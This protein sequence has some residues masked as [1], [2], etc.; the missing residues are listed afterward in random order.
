[1]LSVFEEVQNYIYANEGLSKDVAFREIVKVVACKLYDEQAN[2]E[3][4]FFIDQSELSQVRTEGE[5]SP[6]SQ[7]MARLYGDVSARYPSEFLREEGITLSTR[8]L[9]FLVSR[10]QFLRLSDLNADVKGE[11]FQALFQRYHWGERGEFYTPQPVAKMAVRLLDPHLGERI[12]DPA[13]G[14]GGFLLEV[15]RFLAKKH[16]RVPPEEAG[17]QLYGIEINQ[18]VAMVARLNF[19]LAGAEAAKVFV[20]D[21]L[22][23]G[24]TL[25][26]GFDLVIANP[27]FGSRGKVDD[28]ILLSQYDLGYVWERGP[29]GWR[30]GVT[31]RRGQSPEVLFLELVVR[32]LR[33]GGRAAVV[34]P[35]GESPGRRGFGFFHE[36][37]LHKGRG[38]SLSR[39]G[40]GEGKGGGPRG[41]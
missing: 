24:L 39:Q 34:L 18:H 35:G 26:E 41:G 16:P 38:R 27:P 15:L 4:M 6:F 12:I 3:P 32:L 19:L 13:A 30:K 25:E 23:H 40:P 22:K 21:A 31:I 37:L 1:M 17:G 28:K 33:P 14:S 2:T 20:G 36:E 29:A 7:R 9:A 10:L 11:A 5:C 8:T